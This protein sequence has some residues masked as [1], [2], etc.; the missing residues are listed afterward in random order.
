LRQPFSCLFS[1][2]SFPWLPP[3]HR[4]FDG[5]VQRGERSAIHIRYLSVSN[6]YY[7][8]EQATNLGARALPG[9][10]P[11]GSPFWSNEFIYLRYTNLAAESALVAQSTACGQEYHSGR[12]RYS[13]FSQTTTNAANGFFK[14]RQVGLPLAIESLARFD[15]DG[16]GIDDYYEL[17]HGLTR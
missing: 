5:G 14:V 6:A 4:N 3:R 7:I 11:T 15:Q 10:R 2:F 16:D 17:T 9:W 13:V 12:Q 8:L 1:C